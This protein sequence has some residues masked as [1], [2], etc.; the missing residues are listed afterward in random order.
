MEGSK[1]I[2]PSEKEAVVLMGICLIKTPN[3]VSGPVVSCPLSKFSFLEGPVC[4]PPLLP[5]SPNS[6]P[7]SVSSVQ[8]QGPGCHRVEPGTG[9]PKCTSVA[10]I[11]VLPTRWPTTHARSRSAWLFKAWDPGAELSCVESQLFFL[12]IYLISLNPYFLS[13]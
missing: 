8:V 3:V 7:T 11:S 12:A 1:W 10:T 6:P 2:C 4:T 5:A 13:S 9:V